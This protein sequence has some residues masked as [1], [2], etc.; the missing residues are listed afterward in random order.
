M[1]FTILIILIC[2]T[3]LIFVVRK[4]P[5]YKRLVTVLSLFKPENIAHNF[6]N[7]S[8]LFP[9][10]EIKASQD[11]VTLNKNSKFSLP[12]SFTHKSETNNVEDYLHSSQTSGLIV[13]KDDAI[14]SEKYFDPCSEFTQHISWSVCKSMISAM[15]GIAIREKMIDNLSDPV[16]KYVPYLFKSGYEGTS[17]KDVLQMSTGIDF[18]EDYHDF[19]SDINRL[20]RVFALGRSFD[21][22]VK[23]LKRVRPPGTY[24]NYISMD[25]QVLGMIIK[26]AS[27]MTL[28]S[29]LEKYL[30]K[31]M[32]AE[33]NAYWLTDKFGMEA[34][35]GG[36]NCTLRDYAR[37]GKMYADNGKVNGKQVIP[38]EWIKK[39]TQST[40]PHL[41]AGDLPHLS[42][43]PYGYGY[44]WWLPESETGEYLAMGVYNQF[45]YIDPTHKIVIIKNSSNF[46]YAI[47]KRET[48]FRHLSFFR[49][50]K[51]KIISDEI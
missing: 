35:F 2:I 7:M 11:P 37:F 31:P 46:N 27:G 21:K 44:Q 18:N 41:Q 10:N 42:S 33:S 22:Y 28:S 8:S 50:I 40:E 48:T 25:T 16:E 36:L 51:Q 38:E 9:V 13:L 1:G 24:H 49:A 47:E 39:S 15:V 20:G 23:S 14:L 45:I 32:G 26:E 12:D 29:F 43:H 17:I 5:R 19:R 34:A 4:S 3:A 6:V 30:W